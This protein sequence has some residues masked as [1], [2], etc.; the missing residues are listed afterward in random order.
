[1]DWDFLGD[2]DTDALGDL[3]SVFDGVSFVGVFEGVFFGICG[4]LLMV[5][6]DFSDASRIFFGMS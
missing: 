5:I 1:L 4:A 2:L 6:C 3:D